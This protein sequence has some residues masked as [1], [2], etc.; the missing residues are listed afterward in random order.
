MTLQC[1]L[2]HGGKAYLWTDTLAYGGDHKTPLFHVTKTFH[3]A[4]RKWTGII[5]GDLPP[6]NL[7]MVP[8]AIADAEPK[9]ERQLVDAVIAAVKA[10]HGMGYA[11]RFLFA[12]PCADRGARMFMVA[13][14]D[15]PFTC[16]FR[17]HELVQYAS[18]GGDQLLRPCDPKTPVDMM[19]YIAWTKKLPS[20]HPLGGD[21]IQTEIGMDGM[22]QRRWS[23][24]FERVPA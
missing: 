18:H 19:R 20:P 21:L 15:L 7:H 9:T 4:T 1:G 13:S 5:S 24:Y 8:Q 16:A 11:A 17:A 10:S 22:Q 3:D 12:F 14:E 23:D 2:I 6:D